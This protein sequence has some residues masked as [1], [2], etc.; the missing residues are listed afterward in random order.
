PRSPRWTREGGISANAP[1]RN[2]REVV[3]HVTDLVGSEG[4]VALVS[5]WEGSVRIMS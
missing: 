4:H 3:S 2:W 5:Y 1:T